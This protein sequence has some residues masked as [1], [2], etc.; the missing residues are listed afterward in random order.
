MEINHF[1]EV[2]TNLFRVLK[3]LAGEVGVFFGEFDQRSVGVGIVGEYSDALSKLISDVLK[4]VFDVGCE[5][6]LLVQ[7]CVYVTKHG[8]HLVDD[9]PHSGVE[10][11]FW[12]VS[13]HLVYFAA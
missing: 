5:L 12:I 7:T 13:S 2:I 8:V 10:R 6:F 11:T 4:V 3:F 1:L 9:I